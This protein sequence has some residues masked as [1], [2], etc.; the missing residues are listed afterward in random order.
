MNVYTQKMEVNYTQNKKQMIRFDWKQNSKFSTGNYKIE[1]FN[2]GF[3]IGEAMIPLKKAGI[4][5]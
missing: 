1:V 2:N 5:G 3:K 4:F